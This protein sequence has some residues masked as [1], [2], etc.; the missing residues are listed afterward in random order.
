MLCEDLNALSGTLDVA[1]IPVTTNIDAIDAA[2]MTLPALSE[3][4]AKVVV[5]GVFVAAAIAQELLLQ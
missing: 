4:R 5:V 2:L 1:I 3:G